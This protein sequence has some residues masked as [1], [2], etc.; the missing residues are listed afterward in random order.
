MVIAA[1]RAATMATTIHRIW[2]HVGQPLGDLC[3]AR[4]ASNAPVSANG[5]AKTECSNLIISST[6]R[7]LPA[8]W[9]LRLL[10]LRRGLPGPTEHLLLQEINLREHAANVLRHE[11]VDRFRVM[12]ESGNRR[13]DPHA[14]LV[15][16]QT[17]CHAG[18]VAG[19]VAPS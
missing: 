9:E 14:A 15:R 17:V 3:V 18:A 16:P 13:H 1:E 12:V 10:L 2:L 7:N 8:M 6:M 11:V 19:R 4:A 5:S